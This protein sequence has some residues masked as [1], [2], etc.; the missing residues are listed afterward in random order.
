M[1]SEKRQKEAEAFTDPRDH[2]QRRYE[3]L[4]AFFAEQLTYQQVADRFGVGVWAVVALV[5]AWRAG[6]LDLFAPKA[7]PGPAKG[8]APARDRA[9]G[10]VVELRRGGLSVYEIS[11]RLGQ[12]G[13]PL[14][15]TSVGEVLR[16]E[17]FG[18]LNRR[19][20]GQAS[21]SPATPGRDQG[22]RP[23][24]ALAVSESAPQTPTRHAGLL[25]AL[26]DLAALGLPDLVE[27]A[28]YPSTK[29]IGAA[30]WILALLALKLTGLRRVSHVDDL[31]GDPAAALFAGM[32]HLPKKTAL[33]DYSYRTAP[34]MQDKF[35]LAL[36]AALVREQL[37]AGSGA[38]LDLDFH[39]VAHWGKDP[40]LEKRHVPT[41]SQRSRSVLTFFAQD[42]DTKNLV[43]STADLAKAVQSDQVLDFC[44]HWKK[45]VGHNPAM[46][47]MDQ[48]V[49]THKH[50]AELDRRA[51]KF[52]TLRMRSK[53]LM[54]RIAALG[55]KDFKTTQLDRPGPHNKPKVNDD[56]SVEIRDYPGTVRQLT[57]TGLGRDQPTVIITNDRASTARQLITTYAGRMN[58]EQRL[59][60]TIRS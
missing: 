51:I 7:T 37:A 45:A 14:N 12:E 30:N 19:G 44:D 5:R 56:P 11:A 40:A 52:L 38:V 23:A 47:V 22:L 50:L 39:A 24:R 27:A 10:R 15:R 4:R 21:Q 31:L 42:H 57:A 53:P 33:T 36:D 35:L 25:L 41:R 20:P 9:R 1:A 17:G 8:T 49:T 26:P 6:K 54:E 13:T 55:P 60:E 46:V 32:A 48:K 34:E 18:R 3:M 43:Y 29:A 28:G 58:I 16:E 59:A 2:N